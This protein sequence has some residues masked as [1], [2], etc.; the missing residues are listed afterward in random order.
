MNKLKIYFVGA[1]I[2]M[3]GGRVSAQTMTFGDVDLKAGETDT[4]RI[5]LMNPTPIS[6]WQMKFYLPKGLSL[7]KSAISGEWMF[8]LSSR[9]A[10]DFIYAIDPRAID[11]R[12]EDGC[13]T[14]LCYA[15][16]DTY[17]SSGEGDL[18]ELTFQAD[19]SYTG[20]ASIYVKEIHL[21]DRTARN[22][23]L[24]DVEITNEPTGIRQIYND[25]ASAVLYSLSGQRVN[26]IPQK[27]LYIRNGKKVII[28]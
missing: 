7:A 5:S 17:I 20:T 18:C 19:N 3:T 14:I 2:A 22:I 28:K 12:P 6:A 4:M 27:G 1:V 16:S 26:R 8:S 25:D 24:G 21:S 23:A 9:H 11:P 10:K 15:K 13:Y